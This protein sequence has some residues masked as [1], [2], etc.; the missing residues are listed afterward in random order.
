MK[1]LSPI[2]IPEDISGEGRDLYRAGLVAYKK[3]DYSEAIS[4][5]RGIL[6]KY[7]KSRTASVATFLIGESY[8]SIVSSKAAIEKGK[9]DDGS[10]SSDPDR[11]EALDTF[12]AAVRDFPSSPWVPFGLYRIG[13]LYRQMGLD[14]ESQGSDRRILKEFSTN[15]LASPAQLEIA[16]IYFRE[17]KFRDAYSEYQR[18]LQN[19]PD[20]E[21]VKDAVYESADTLYSLGEF[22]DAQRMYDQGIV[23]WP[24]YLKSYPD[25]LSRFG[26]TLFQNGEWAQSRTAFFTLY[27]LYPSHKQ[28]GVALNRIGDSYRL[29]GRLALARGIY[30]EIMILYREG[31]PPVL[32][33]IALGDAK[34]KEAERLG[35]RP[36]DQ[37]AV[38]ETAMTY[39]MEVSK[40]DHRLAGEA[41]LKMGKV[42]ENRGRFEEAIHIYETVLDRP[43]SEKDMSVI[44]TQRDDA[45]RSVS[46]LLIML[47]SQKTALN[48]D[49]GLILLYQKHKGL[50]HDYLRDVS[51]L[52][53]IAEAHER[54]GIY[55]ESALLFQVLLSVTDRDRER[56]IFNQGEDYLQA[57]DPSAAVQVLE[58]YRILYPR[59]TY[60]AKASALM[61]EAL[62]DKGDYSGITVLTTWDNDSMTSGFILFRVVDSFL[63]TGQPEKAKELLKKSVT[64]ISDDGKGSLGMLWVTLGNVDYQEGAYDEAWDSYRKGMSYLKETGDR[65]F[66]QLMMSRSLMKM[67]QGRKAQG[68]LTNLSS[69]RSETYRQVIDEW[70]REQEENV[71]KLSASR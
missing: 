16:R 6:D 8:F 47:A 52:Q 4:K 22:G 37:E 56:F 68:F 34:G 11:M 1:Q 48:D 33:R 58:A 20:T 18:F 62:Y 5:W 71:G 54:L 45:V 69:N 27:N 64:R 39:F 35:E 19:Y 15:S 70:K 30:Q 21:N 53:H 65:D 55:S 7:P 12:Q 9:A 61:V 57:G 13:E 23:R 49:M 24:A 50:F 3:R 28:A 26:E 32:A 60:E 14:V 29:E 66:A 36:I 31:D 43:P 59:G 38:Y 2:S 17:G 41:S 42:M 46:A 10:P 63:R 51:T 44:S 25:S 67:G 40:T